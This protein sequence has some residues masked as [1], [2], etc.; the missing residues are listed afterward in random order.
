MKKQANTKQNLSSIESEIIR[1]LK[2]LE[3]EVISLQ[4]QGLYDD[5]FFSEPDNFIEV[6][7][8]HFLLVLENMIKFEKNRA[9]NRKLGLDKVSLNKLE[10]K[11]LGID[12]KEIEKQTRKII[13]K[14]FGNKTR[15][16]SK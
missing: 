10:I 16:K 6:E 15:R 7:F 11:R 5:M 2:F 8:E 13:A 3:V 14:L 9:I 4:R 1:K 12:F